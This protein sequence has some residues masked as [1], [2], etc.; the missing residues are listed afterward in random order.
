MSSLEL[1]ITNSATA[2]ISGS[3]FFIAHLYPYMVNTVYLFDLFYC[4]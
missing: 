3:S 1:I 2:R 4:V